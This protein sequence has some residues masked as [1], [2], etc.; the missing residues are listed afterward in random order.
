MIVLPLLFLVQ[1]QSLDQARLDSVASMRAAAR[2]AVTSAPTYSGVASQTTIE[3]PRLTGRPVIDGILNDVQ[4]TQAARLTGFSQ[5]N[6]V[7][8]KPAEDSTVAFV[9]YADDAIYFGVRAYAPPGTVHGTL[10]DRDKI[11]NDDHIQF[12]LDTYNDN[13][14][15]FVF[16]V[17]PLGIQS[18]GVR[19]EGNS[20]GR[21]M[22]MMGGGGGGGGGAGGSGVS[23]LNLTNADLSQDMIWESKGR[24]TDFGYEV[25]VRIPFKA[26]RFLPNTHAWGINVVRNT[27]RNNFQDS[28]APV[29]RGN[30]S[31]LVQSGRLNA[32]HDLKR[33]LVL[34]VT[35]VVTSLTSGAPTPIPGTTTNYFNYTSQQRFGG[36]V[37]WGLTPNLT[38]NG[39]MRPDFSQVEADAGQIPG[40]VRFSLF[41]PELRP[42]FVEGGENFDAPQQLVYTRN[43]VQPVAATKLTGKVGSTDIAV[44]SAMDG[45]EYS[46]SQTQNPLFNVLRLRRD[47]GAQSTMGFVLTDRHEGNNFNRVGAVDGRFVFRSVYALAIQAGASQTDTGSGPNFG[48]LW[49]ASIDRSGRAYG[50]RNSLK[51]LS[52]E[53]GSR[54]GFVNRTNV[55]DYNGN[56][57]YSW[58]GAR[59]SRVEQVMYS[60][61]GSSIWNYA[62]FFR[63]AV[64]LEMRGS[65]SATAQ[66]RGG[67]SVSVTPSLTSDRFDSTSY[68]SYYLAR[69]HGA[70]TDTVK[71][72]PGPTVTS[73]Q[74][75][76]RISTPQF[77]TFA[78]N[79]SS[80]YGTD[81]EYLESAVATRLDVS[82]NLDLRP[83]SS[84]RATLTMLHQEFR[85]ERDKSAILMTNIPRL[86]VEYQLTR[87]LLARFVGQYENRTRDAYRDPVTN[88]PILFKSSTGKFSATSRTVTNNM[89]ADWLIAYLPSPGRVIYV[90]YGASLTQTDP[91][92]FSD[93][94][95]R[96]SDGLFVK[97]SY[98][99]RVQ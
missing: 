33:G 37:R 75:Q 29:R 47:M 65:L 86:R 82:A 11:T 40:D 89:R 69:P 54:V 49:D 90:G 73:L 25:E 96:T 43:I 5:Y 27:Q 23:R 2:V 59:G 9:W 60:L 99:F 71:F 72:R 7:D 91:F 74:W 10:A 41:F 85:R 19:S 44:L 6:P 68:A 15:A 66:L 80:T 78:A 57:R 93:R 16:A 67:W 63:G 34:D 48:R 52:R 98:Q 12:I 1:A 20:G 95:E 50:F 24:I 14:R 21:M 53:F 84:M 76:G 56:Q 61:N 88:A 17:N 18:D 13:R 51:G 31:I 83:T 35:P 36:D 64:P 30:T 42:F 38:L 46:A 58:F 87:T 70:T 55:V 92:S 3:T 8:G 94:P 26:V 28:W 81:A 32:I 62:D 39:T 79:V 4:W 97:L 22:M 77:S 45:R